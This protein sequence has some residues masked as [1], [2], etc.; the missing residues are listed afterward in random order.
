MREAKKENKEIRENSRL[1]THLRAHHRLK[2]SA[3]N[4]LIL[5]LIAASQSGISNAKGGSTVEI[6]N[7]DVITVTA[8]RTERHVSDI[9]NTVSVID[10]AQIQREIANGI[11]DLIRYEPG[12]SVSGSGR[13]GLNSFSIRGIGGDRVLTLV[14]NT[15]TADE[16]SFGPFL[17]SRRDFV[18]LDAL[19]SVEIVRGP[20]SSVYGSNAIGGVVNFITKDPGDYLNG[21]AFTG[22]VKVGASSVDSSTNVTLLTAFGNDVLSAMV[23]GTLRDSSE[24]E[25]FFSD[26]ASGPQR[27]SENPQKNEN[28]N[29]YAK[30]VYA[31]SDNQEISLVAEAF[32][33]D[34]ETDVLSAAQ[35]VSRG[36]LTSQQ[37]GL[38]ERSRERVSID[39]ELSLASALADSINLLAYSQRSD[40]LQNTLTER[41]SRSA[42]QDRVRTSTYEQENIGVRAQLGKAFDTGA[43][44]HNIV[45]GVDYDQSEAVTL[46]EGQ[47]VNR[48]DG[49]L[50]REFSNFPT[51]DFPNSEYISLGAFIQDE[52]AFADGRLRLIPAVRYDNFELNPTADAIY[53][54]GNTGSPTPEGYDESEVSAKLGLVYDL[55][56][57]WTVFAQYAEGFRAPPLD[58][59]NTGFTNFAG[60][61]TTLPN[62]NLRPERGKSVE[63]GFRR[64]SDYGRF[65][66]TAY[67]NTYEDFIESLAV[68]GFNPVTR[69]LEF[70]ARNLDEAE[71]KGVEVK[72]QYQLS[73]LSEKLSGLQVRAA[74]A[75]A[76]GENIENGQPLNSIDP[77]QLVLGL[78]FMPTSDKWSIE[79][80]IT[81][82]DRK[83]TSD[84]DSTS[85]QAVDEPVIAP[86]ETPGFAVL[87][88]IGHYTLSDK[89]R[90]NWGV[91]NVTDKQHYQ[92][93]E[94]LVQNPLTTNFDRF[95]EPGRN[96]SVTF[97][98]TL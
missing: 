90:L 1:A 73:A 11:D 86:F 29:I 85:L 89:A 6:E 71:I 2:K 64:F 18:D 80:V 10:A 45:Y 7:Q 32:E 63:L 41:L 15:P 65:E 77:Q 60:G 52:I 22:S 43:L 76:H 47:T 93:S 59:V 12:V 34:S 50:A 69:L 79:A 31:L 9:A 67:K 42:T 74:Y 3:I 26:S 72:T 68:R 28:Q 16:F 48:A 20:G 40:A 30:F 56:E 8:T 14:D 27:R 13:F 33:A 53:L 78:G 98:Y 38:D 35:T 97:K 61:Y 75:Y 57:Q 44:S 25:A 91:F 39:Y 54:S 17:S 23:L 83:Q 66:V 24:N 37:V 5:A 46:R 21:Q 95:T 84:I 55:N 81:A 49:S 51:R 88:L 94:G 82:T 92:W 19:K 62:Q 58:A 87:D 4:S 36:V 70:Q 96:Y